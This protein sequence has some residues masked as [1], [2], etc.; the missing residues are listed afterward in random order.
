MSRIR[1]KNTKS[2]LILRKILMG[3]Y[4]RSYPNISGKPD[5]G[6]KKRKIAVF[7]DGCFWHKCPQHFIMPKSNKK[8]WSKK[9]EN[10]ILRDR[11]ITKMLK[12]QGYK[13]IRIWEHKIKNTNKLKELISA[14]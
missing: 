10:N 2:E 6:N 1:S 3:K 7:L 11:N 8:Y 14:L 4:L 12:K 13:V 5:F 9:I